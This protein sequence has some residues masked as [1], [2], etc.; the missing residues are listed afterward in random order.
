[1]V[2]IQSHGEI[3]QTTLEDLHVRVR[4]F[5]ISISELSIYPFVFWA[6]SRCDNQ[7]ARHGEAEL[8]GIICCVSVHYQRVVFVFEDI[9]ILTGRGKSAS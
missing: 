7:R 8:L 6:T 4:V 5:G 1:M 2:D 9:H 3:F